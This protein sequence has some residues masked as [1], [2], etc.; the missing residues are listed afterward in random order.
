L[1]ASPAVAEN[2]ARQLIYLADGFFPDRFG[3]LLSSVDGTVSVP[4]RFAQICSLTAKSCSPNS[5]KRRHSATSRR[6]LARLGGEEN[7]SVTVFPVH[8][9]RQPKVGTVAC[10]A[11]FMAMTVRVSTTATSSCNGTSAHVTQPSHLRLNAGAAIFKFNQRI[12]H[13]GLLK[14]SVQFR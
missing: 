9:T 5:R 10:V 11:I 1:A 4:G 8:L 2:N 3:R 6:A 13:L 14:P 7:I 12:G